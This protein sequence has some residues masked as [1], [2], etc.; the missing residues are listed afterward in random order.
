MRTF[1]VI[2]GVL[3]LAVVV[4]LSVGIVRITQANPGAWPS[5]A[6]DLK[7]GRLPTF[8]AE[9]GSIAVTTVNTTVAVP[10]LE[11]VPAGES[12]AAPAEAPTAQ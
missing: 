9:T 8:T 6:V 12:S 5:V 11:V 1:L 7:G 4:L 2:A 3:S 10:A